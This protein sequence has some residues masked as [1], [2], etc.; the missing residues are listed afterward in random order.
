MTDLLKRAK[1]LIEDASENEIVFAEEVTDLI[2]ELYDKLKEREWQPIET[3]PAGAPLFMRTHEGVEFV[4]EYCACYADF[5][6]YTAGG[7]EE[8]QY[9]VE[10]KY[11]TKPNKEINNE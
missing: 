11:A 9:A 5:R 6:R 3:A 1:K 4:G 8:F 7:L 10:W 2:Q